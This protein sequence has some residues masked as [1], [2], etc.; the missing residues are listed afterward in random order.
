MPGEIWVVG[1]RSGD[2]PSPWT[3]QLI[4]GA[5]SL[6]EQAGSTVG[7]LQPDAGSQDLTLFLAHGAATV[8]S[9]DVVGEPAPVELMV[10][11][12]GSLMT[13][14][15]P[16]LLMLPDNIRGRDIAGRIAAASD[17]PLISGCERVAYGEDGSLTLIRSSYRGQLSER[18]SAEFTPCV[19]TIREHAFRAL[20]VAAPSMWER[21]ELSASP[22]KTVEV[23]E[24]RAPAPETLDLEE[25]EV[26][27]SGGLGVGEEGFEGLTELARLLGGTT[28]AS[29]AAVDQGWVPQSKQVG[30]TGRTVEPRLYFA[31][32]ISGALQHMVGIRDAGTLVALNTDERAPVMREAD[33]AVVGDAATVIPSLLREIRD[34]GQR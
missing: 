16:S 11:A 29:R 27:V 26:L 6:A 3:L 7:V 5:H 21:R 28:A 31:C 24:R 8:A 9:F 34:G 20:Q 30:Q 33:L 15:H 17:V 13:T 1:E 10:S 19:A 12:V 25:A 23:L 22:D 32:G 4:S 18:I 14:S 2:A